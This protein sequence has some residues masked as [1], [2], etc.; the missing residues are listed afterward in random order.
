M[1]GYIHKSEV[2][3]CIFLMHSEGQSM[4]DRVGQQLGNY[5]LVRLLGL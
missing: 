1:Q 4:A 3:R 5:R 2:K